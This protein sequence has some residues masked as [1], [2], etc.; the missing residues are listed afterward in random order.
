MHLVE[1]IRKVYPE[2]KDTD[3]FS[4]IIVQDD[5]DGNGPY[6]KQWNHPTLPRPTQEQLD[7]VT[8]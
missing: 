6:I 2:L 5:S 7:A 8:E 4:I 3:F 1:K